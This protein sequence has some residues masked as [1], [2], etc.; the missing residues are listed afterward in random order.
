MLRLMVC[1]HL[2]E[3][4]QTDYEEPAGYEEQPDYEEPPSLPPRSDDLSEDEEQEEAD[5][6]RA[7]P[8]LPQEEDYEDVGSYIPA[9]LKIVTFLQ[10]DKLSIQ[11]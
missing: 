8:P 11:T 5:L 1:C 4:E 9:G 7:P 6:H 2:Q 3:E 10:F